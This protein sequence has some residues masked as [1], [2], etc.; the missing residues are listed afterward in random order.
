MT[1]HDLA[2]AVVPP[3]GPE[4]ADQSPLRATPFGP[5]R[6]LMRVPVEIGTAQ[7]AAAAPPP[8]PA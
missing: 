6:P 2:P 7:A 5:H 3:S 1:S 8:E 4:P